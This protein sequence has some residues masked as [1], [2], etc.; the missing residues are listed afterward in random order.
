MDFGPHLLLCLVAIG[1]ASLMSSAVGAALGTFGRLG[2]GMVSAIT[3][4][5]SLFIGLY[6]P[7]AQSLA[8]SVE[9]SAPLLAQVNPL[10]QA[11]RCFYGLLYYDSLAPFARSCAVL[12]GMAGL[13]LTIALLRARRMSHEHL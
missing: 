7:G 6:S 2:V 9:H 1:V 12:T 3:C 4:L 11:S 10:W 8:D 5:L 13:F